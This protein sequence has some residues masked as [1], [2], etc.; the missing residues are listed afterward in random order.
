MPPTSNNQTIRSLDGIRGLAALAIVLFHNRFFHD[1]APAVASPLY[2][3][4]D[5]FF[6]LSGFVIHLTYP[7]LRSWASVQS[8]V[9]KR[10]SRLYPLFIVTTVGH[11]FM[12]NLPAALGYVDKYWLQIPTNTI[13]V[14]YPSFGEA[15]ALLTL[16]HSLGMFESLVGNYPSWS[17][18]TE[19]YTYLLYALL[20][21]WG[22]PAWRASVLWISIV[23]CGAGSIVGSLSTED[24]ALQGR[25][26][27]VSYDFGIYRCI[28]A[29][30]LGC[31]AQRFSLRPWMR[32]IR[33]NAAVQICSLAAAGVVGLGSRFMPELAFSAPLLATILLVSVSSD[34]GPLSN[35]L[36]ARICLWL[37]GISYSMYLVHPLVL[38]LVGYLLPSSTL[39]TGTITLWVYIMAVLY[40]SHK[41]Y[42][43]LELPA[44]KYLRNYFGYR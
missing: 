16:S 8:F 6:C 31:I 20:L 5:V 42:V 36:S 12:V 33:G 15:V 17:I 27:N 43:H 38:K 2:L 7:E 19:W 21:I 35:L 39:V 32:Y 25:C 40:I 34:S 23:V 22:R 14:V 30:S 24:C 26:N 18:S 9:V 29:F 28:F 13:R 4:V 44:Q 1:A 10:F 41:S 37:G 3:C 11:Y